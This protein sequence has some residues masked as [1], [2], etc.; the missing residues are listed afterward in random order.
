MKQII[1]STKFPATHPRKGQPT[2]FIEKIWAGLA[3]Q[4]QTMDDFDYLEMDFHEYYNASPKLHTIRAGKRWKEGDEFQGKIWSGRP[5]WSKTIIVTPILTVER[6]YYLSMI[7]LSGV[8]RVT[9]EHKEMIFGN[10]IDDQLAVNDG[11][12]YMDFVGWFASK[13]TIK[14]G[15]TGQIICWNKKVKYG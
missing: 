15:F 13:K 8:P 1:F 14:Y 10:F 3:D 5:Y 9:V 12:S 2:Y 4:G 6:V 11:L 7:F